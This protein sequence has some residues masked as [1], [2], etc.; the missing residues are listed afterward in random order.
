MDWS[1]RLYEL[2]DSFDTHDDDS[3]DERYVIDVHRSLVW[4]ELYVHGDVCMCRWVGRFDDVLAH[5]NVFFCAQ[6]SS[7]CFCTRYHYKRKSDDEYKRNNMD[8]AN[9]G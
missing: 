1:D 5:Y 9:V 3:N 7:S 8:R 2:F 4:Y 6:T